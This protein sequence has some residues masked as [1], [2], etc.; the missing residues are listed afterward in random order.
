MDSQQKQL[1]TEDQVITPLTD[2]LTSITSG[3]TSTYARQSSSKH[4]Q[5]LDQLFPEQDYEEKETKEAK[6]ILQELAF[7][8]SP[9]QLKNFTVEAKL[10]VESWIDEYEREIFNG[11]TLQELL[12][13]KGSL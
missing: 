3:E 10:L 13:E 4:M 8:L 11:L 7:E 1:I 12:H 6:K 5:S 9:E 2:V